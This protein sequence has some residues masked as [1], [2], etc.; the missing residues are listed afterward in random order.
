[1]KAF[2]N[3]ETK[4][5]GSVMDD[6]VLPSEHPLLF[7]DDTNESKPIRGIRVHSNGYKLTPVTLSLVEETT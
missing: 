4:T 2:Y 7:P 6:E 3:A 5:W 1:M